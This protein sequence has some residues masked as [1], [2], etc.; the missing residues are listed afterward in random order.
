MRLCGIDSSSRFTAISLFINGEYQSFRLIDLHKMQDSEERIN[1]MILEIYTALNIYKP[2]V[3]YQEFT[4]VAKNP[5]T[6]LLLT[7]IIGAVKGWAVSHECNFKEIAPSAW[8][9]ILGLNEYKDNRKELK[10][11]AINYIEETIGLTPE[12]DDVAD[13]ICI[14]FAGCKIE[15]IAGSIDFT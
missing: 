5:K 14:G 8:R 10:Q 7:I 13:A 6:A 9:K 12:T 1:Q 4:W 2:N 15:S 3:I 11:K